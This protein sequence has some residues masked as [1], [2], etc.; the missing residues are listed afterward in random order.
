MHALIPCKLAKNKNGIFLWS[1]D[2]FKVFKEFEIKVVT[3]I[4]SVLNVLFSR[5]LGLCG[6]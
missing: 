4:I 1:K 5:V 3:A 2:P 6:E